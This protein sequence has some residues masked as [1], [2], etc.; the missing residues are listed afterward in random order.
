MSQLPPES[1]RLVALYHQGFR[2]AKIDA[3]KQLA[4]E[5]QIPLN[6]LRI[7]MYRVRAGLAKSVSSCVQDKQAAETNLDSGH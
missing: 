4:E 6:A 7:R 3:R 2:R 1:R 5:L